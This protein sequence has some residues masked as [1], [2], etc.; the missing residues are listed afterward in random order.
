MTE[1]IHEQCAIISEEI[2]N[3][4]GNGDEKL[5]IKTQWLSN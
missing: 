1:S 4:L 3:I 2:Y 5:F